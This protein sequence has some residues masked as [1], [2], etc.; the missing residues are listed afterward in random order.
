V[1]T[2]RRRDE[3]I[4]RVIELGA[5]MIADA[6]DENGSGWGVMSDPDGNQCCILRSDAERP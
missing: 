6:R 4:D 1:P 5:R 2:D 3:E